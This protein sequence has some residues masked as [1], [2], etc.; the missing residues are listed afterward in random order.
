MFCLKLSSNTTSGFPKLG[1]IGRHTWTWPFHWRDLQDWRC[2]PLCRTCSAHEKS[3]FYPTAVSSTWSICWRCPRL[4]L[5]AQRLAKSL[6]GRRI[7]SVCTWYCSIRNHGP[8]WWW[9]SASRCWCLYSTHIYLLPCF[10]YIKC[11]SGKCDSLTSIEERG[12]ERSSRSI[13][14]TEIRKDP[15]LLCFAGTNNLFTWCR[16][17]YNSDKMLPVTWH[18]WQLMVNLILARQSEAL[19]F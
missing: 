11:G 14:K 1:Y 5:A 12:K 8:A 7:A 2:W 16:T 17:C 13:P 6:A 18:Q 4:V 9:S 19:L 10:M 3:A 15:L